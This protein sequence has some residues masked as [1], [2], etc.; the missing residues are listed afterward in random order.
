MW[1]LCFP[2]DSDVFIDFYFEKIY[3]NEETLLYLI[4]KKP[5]ASF[6][7][8]PFP[9][10]VG[11][12]IKLSGYISGAMTHPD[13]QGKG[14]MKEMLNTSCEIMKEKC[15]EYSFLIPQEDWLFDYYAK[16]GYQ[17]AF[18]FSLDP[19]TKIDARDT[20]SNVLRDKEVQIYTHLEEVDIDNFYSIY[21]RFLMEQDSA[22]LK[23][24]KQIEY[25]L[26]DFFIDHGVLFLND[27]G[28]AFT[29]R[30]SDGIRLKEFF[31]FDPEIRSEFLITISDYFKTKKLTIANYSFSESSKYRGMIKPLTENNI[32]LVEN[33]YMSMMLD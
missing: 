32:D 15:Y 5:V 33:T 3:K 23:P 1:K 9:I 25:I 21:Y 14:I 24:K 4:D 8:L 7:I 29:L 22:V 6:Q 28:L 11:N 16:F 27:W 26:E 10:K 2:M 19:I 17:E 31:Y 12:S 20:E 30:K 18:P 13:F